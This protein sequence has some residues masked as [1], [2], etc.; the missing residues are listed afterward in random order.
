MLI[1]A[2]DRERSANSCTRIASNNVPLDSLFPHLEQVSSN[3]SVQGSDFMMI[4]HFFKVAVS[5]YGTM[6]LDGIVTGR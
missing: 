6:K 1:L 5:N 4:H 2:R 3:A